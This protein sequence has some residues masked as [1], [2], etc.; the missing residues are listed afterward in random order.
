MRLLTENG[1]L[2]VD[3]FSFLQAFF[4]EVPKR[5]AAVGG[6]GKTSFL[7]AAAQSAPKEKRT[8]LTASAKMLLPE[9]EFRF[10]Y[11]KCEE[12]SFLTGLTVCGVPCGNGKMTCSLSD[13]KRIEPLCDYLLIE[14]DGSKGLPLK[15]PD[16]HEPVLPQCDLICG[17]AGISAVDGRIKD[18]CHRPALAAKTLQTDEAHLISPDDV[19]FLLSSKY[20]QRKNVGQTPYLALVGQAD[21]NPTAALTAV[22]ALKQRGITAA[23]VSFR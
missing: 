12:M 18:I 3:V 5:I 1:F 14:A 17:F 13:I 7:Y 21:F 8:V 10:C 22:Q 9:K 23:A 15:A 16:F 6:G 20:G 11:P 2:E 4:S 19:A